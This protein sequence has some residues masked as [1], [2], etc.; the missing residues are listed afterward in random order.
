MIPNEP[1]IPSPIC[2]HYRKHET[3]T[4]TCQRG[5]PDPKFK[6][7]KRYS[8]FNSSIRMKEHYEM[9]C[10]KHYTACKKYRELQKSWGKESV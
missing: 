10:C 1:K 8:K 7:P 6:A 9:G 5:D 4:I 2:P 3:T